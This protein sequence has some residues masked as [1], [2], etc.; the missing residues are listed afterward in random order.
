MARMR[1]VKPEIWT[2]RKF[3]RLSPHARLLFIGMWN[4]AIC[5][6]GH[7]ED[8]AFE[9]KMRV[10]PAD[11]IDASP[12]VDELIDAGLVDR[13]DT[14]LTIRNLSKHQKVDS[15]WTPR[16]PYCPRS[17]APEN[18]SDHTGTPD[19]SANLSETLP[20]STK[21]T[22][23]GDGRGGD[24]RGEEGR[25]APKRATA[26][27]KSWTPSEDHIAYATENNIDLTHEAEKFKNNCA[28][29]GLTYKNHNAAFAN[30]IRQPWVRKLP[31]QQ[32]TA[33]AEWMT[34]G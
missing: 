23:G 8:D 15:R 4:F 22:Q 7:I 25:E 28:A 13:S 24:R 16:C 1:Y 12:L 14:H 27:P 11:N 3:V 21:N 34:R 17:E 26:L 32:P 5:D 2:D 18:S 9:L 10:F 19:T 33:L 30:W 31:D 29:K 6:R 20:S